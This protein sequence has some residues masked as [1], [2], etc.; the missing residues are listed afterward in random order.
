MTTFATMRNVEIYRN[1][2]MQR[3]R[4]AEMQDDGDARPLDANKQ[5]K[6]KIQEKKIKD[7]RSI[8]AVNQG[9][10]YFTTRIK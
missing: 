2:E 5:I 8:V 3:C 10:R 6:R 4:D 7:C 9:T 1:A